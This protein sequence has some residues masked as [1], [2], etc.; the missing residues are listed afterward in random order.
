[1]IAK[2]RLKS[3]SPYSQSKVV[4]S[5]KK[6]KETHDAHEARTWQERLSVNE[7]GYVIIPAMA[8][9]FCLEDAC[10]RL[11]LQVPGKGKAT[12]T[13]HFKS[14]L[15]VLEPAVLGVK[16]ADVP[17]EWFF[18]PSNGERGGGKRVKK[19]FPKI[20][21]WETTVEFHLL[22][23]S[24]TEEVFKQVLIEAGRS[25]GLGRFRPQNSGFYGRFTVE[26]LE[27]IHDE[28]SVAA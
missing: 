27:F 6:Q 7:D 18:V 28:A 24:I 8:F 3:A 9:K 22:S 23:E 11:G 12:Y 26:S 19:C 10:Q 15:L 5:P 16:A 25:I 20:E 4:E 17:G 2:A 1:M 21:S 14:D 13:K